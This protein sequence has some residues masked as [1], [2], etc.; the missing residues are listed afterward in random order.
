ME[1]HSVQE[2]LELSILHGLKPEQ[3]QWLNDH[4]RYCEDCRHKRKELKLMIMAVRNEHASES[5]NYRLIRQIMSQTGQACRVVQRRRCTLLVIAGLSWAAAAVLVFVSVVQLLPYYRKNINSPSSLHVEVATLWES[6]GVHSVPRVH[7]DDIVVEGAMAYM[8]RNN[9]VVAL[10]AADGAVQWK[11]D[12]P[13]Q[14][15]LVVDEKRLFCLGRDDYGRHELT[16]LDRCSGEILWQYRSRGIVDK[17]IHRPAVMDEKTVCWIAHPSMVLLDTE[18]GKVL[19]ERAFGGDSDLSRPVAMYDDIYVAEGN[20]LHCFAMTNGN[21]L[22]RDEVAAG[23]CPHSRPEII[24]MAD[25]LLIKVALKDGRNELICRSSGNHN[26]LW[27]KPTERI[28]H[29]LA[30]SDRVY[31]R[32]RS[33]EALDSRTGEQL[34]A[35]EAQGCGP[36][37]WSAGRL[38][39]VDTAEKGRIVSLDGQTGK[40]CWE[41]PG[42]RSCHAFIQKG[43][44]G[45]LKTQSGTLMAFVF[46]GEMNF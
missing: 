16:A 41:I 36:L 43:N 3:E 2:L 12:L 5:I 17:A 33:V 26:I 20:R 14:G 24:D 40:A 19:W 10:G 6:E 4:I 13:A 28:T 46:N 39:Y 23:V 8:V 22:R 11:A 25:K 21:L 18:K 1:C 34:W 35:R 38:S 44:H 29:I 30:G 45:Y 31:I 15:H 32:G 9:A 27:R 37:S 7:A 42:L